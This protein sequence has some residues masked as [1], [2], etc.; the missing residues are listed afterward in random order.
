[1]VVTAAEEG[2]IC[3]N[4]GIIGLDESTGLLTIAVSGNRHCPG[5][6][7]ATTLSFTGK[8]RSHVGH[9]IGSGSQ[10]ASG[11]TLIVPA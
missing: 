2:A 7:P 4:L 11:S 9:A 3:I 10:H 1:V 5:P 8:E 6:C